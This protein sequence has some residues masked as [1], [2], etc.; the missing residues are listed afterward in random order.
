MRYRSYRVD[1]LVGSLNAVEAK[2]A[3]DAL[4]VAGRVELLRKRP[5]VSIVGTRQPSP[6]GIKLAQAVAQVVCARG[7]IVVSGL[8]RGIDTAAH[9]AALEA[10]GETIAV[11]GTPLDRSYPAENR[12][13]QHSLMMRHLVVSQFAEGTPTSRRSFPMRNR[14]MAL[15]SDATIIIEAGEKSGTQ[16]QGWEAIRL[17]RL[18]FLPQS[19]ID[20]G[21]SWARS[22]LEY[23]ALTYVD[24]E[25]VGGLLDQ[26]L[27]PSASDDDLR[28]TAIGV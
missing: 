27:P 25:A 28:L 15:L 17:G 7:G 6:R 19:V 16:H 23:G 3:P 22:M 26:Y 20:A 18:L 1:E 9:K 13:L 5:R 11:I 2:H 21:T 12:Q 8:A 14:T 24:A 4:Y 10:N